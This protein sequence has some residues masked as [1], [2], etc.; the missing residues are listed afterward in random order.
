MLI[1]S[2]VAWG[3]GFHFP[4]HYFKVCAH[5]RCKASTMD[6]LGGHGPVKGGA[7]HVQEIG[8]LFAPMA[9]LD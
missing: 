5:L 4:S 8:H 6:I 2:L 9:F 3:P 1:G 7:I